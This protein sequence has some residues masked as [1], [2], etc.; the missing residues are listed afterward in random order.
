MTPQLAPFA[1]F[2]RATRVCAL[3]ALVAAAPALAAPP[4]EGADRL[5]ALGL[6]GPP[7][8]AHEAELGLRPAA[9]APRPDVLPGP[10]AIIPGETGSP[11]DAMPAYVPQT[12]SIPHIPLPRT[13]GAEALV[14]PMLAGRLA[15][16]T[17]ED[18]ALRHGA[19]DLAAFQAFYAARE[20]APLWLDLSAERVSWTDAARALA[21]VLRDAA[22]EGL[23]PAAYPVPD[24]PAGPE[25]DAGAAAE[26][27]IALS[28]SLVRYAQHARGGRLQP[29]RLHKLITP[30]LEVPG[31]HAVLAALA[32]APDPAATLAAYQPRHEGY[33]RLRDALA[34]LRAAGETPE[35]M[36][37]VPPGRVLKVGMRDDRVPLLRARFGMEPPPETEPQ[38]YDV[39]LA[40]AVE[41]FQR[42]HGLAVDGVVGNQTIAALA[43]VD[44]ARR[45]GDLIA[46]M[47]RWRWLPQELGDRAVFVNVPAYRMELLD[48]G[49]VVHEARVIVGKPGQETP[50]FSDVMEYVVVSPTWT[51]PPSIM[52]NEFLPGLRADP[53]Y[54]AARGFEV[55]QNGNHITVRQPPGPRNALGD[56]KFMFPN[57]HHVYLH[58]TPSRGLFNTIRR[59]YSHGCV[60]VEDPFELADFLLA[61]QGWPKER[62]RRLIGPRERY[63]HLDEPVPVH[64]A[65]FTLEADSE[66]RI[67]PHEDIYGF[68][69]LTR[70]ALGLDP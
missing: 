29:A 19:E 31:A 41:D 3:L 35:P 58:D 40:A 62:L 48:D 53:N 20:N 65:Y 1:P 25:I 45:E 68:D 23:D 11:L 47:E 9:P 56:I 13:V 33:A 50:I 52:R 64:L 57:G 60:R 49:A 5:A 39:A 51:V 69:A 7:E 14:G 6:A 10:A 59:A 44:P 15:G 43:S 37:R 32:E 27:E 16:L 22:A 70:E 2:R 34:E 18:L 24:L 42:E 21:A 26:A 54:A 36:V 55:I 12:G 46:N 30:T 28:A 66:G 63:V 38:V 61:E 4:A 8:T 17:A 67:V